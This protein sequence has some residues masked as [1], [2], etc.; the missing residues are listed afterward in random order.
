MQ[1]GKPLFRKSDST[2]IIFEL[3]DF[4][5]HFSWWNWLFWPPTAPR[6]WQTDSRRTCRAYNSDREIPTAFESPHVLLFKWTQ[7]Q[8]SS[9]YWQMTRVLGVIQLVPDAFEHRTHQHDEGAHSGFVINASGLTRGLLWTW[10][11]SLWHK[12]TLGETQMP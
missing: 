6:G 4:E 11:S 7:C 2:G 10:I 5:K 1:L 8:L 3:K 12:N 9:V